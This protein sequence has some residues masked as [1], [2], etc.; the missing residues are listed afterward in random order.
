MFFRSK[1]ILIRGCC[2][3][4]L[5]KRLTIASLQRINIDHMAIA[6]FLRNPENLSP[7]V[8]DPEDL[9]CPDVISILGNLIDH[10]ENCEKHYL[11]ISEYG[12]MITERG[13]NV[14]VVEGTLLDRPWIYVPIR[15]MHKHL[16]QHVTE[17]DLNTKL[18]HVKIDGREVLI[19]A[20][21]EM[22]AVPLQDS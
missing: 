7:E 14:R 16:G 9:F 5:S 10:L 18:N 4:P 13:Q 19:E 6:M 3:P 20:A 21:L 17:V 22:L 1:V 2:R 12:S 8:N 15:S 11:L